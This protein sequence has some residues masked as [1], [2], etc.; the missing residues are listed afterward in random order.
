[1]SICTVPCPNLLGPSIR[2]SVFAHAVGPVQATSLKVSVRGICVGAE[3]LVAEVGL[4]EIEV[5]VGVLEPHPIARS[6]TATTIL[7]RSIASR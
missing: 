2:G 1:M 5:A 7:I 4:G 3:G 6:E